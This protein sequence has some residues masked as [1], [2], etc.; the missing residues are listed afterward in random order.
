MIRG[1]VSTFLNALGAKEN[2]PQL[3]RALALVGGTPEVESFVDGGVKST[4]LSLE[5]GGVEFLLT[6]GGTAHPHTPRSTC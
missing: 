6:D 2:D 5:D 4:Y 1:D 3:E